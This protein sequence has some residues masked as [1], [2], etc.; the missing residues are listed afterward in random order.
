MKIQWNRLAAGKS[1]CLNFAFWW[2]LHWGAV[3]KSVSGSWPA[4]N[5]KCENDQSRPIAMHS[6][7]SGC[8][9]SSTL[10]ATC[11]FKVRKKKIKWTER[12]K[13][14]EFQRQ[15]LKYVDL[16]HMCPVFISIFF[17]F[18]NWILYSN[19]ILSIFV[20]KIA[21]HLCQNWRRSAFHSCIN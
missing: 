21:Y 9:E 3:G 8:W 17:F 10:I 12:M 18:S 14:H 13:N 16:H 6:A 1:A 19:C 15:R 7:S 5:K 4:G 11:W 2:E 20:V